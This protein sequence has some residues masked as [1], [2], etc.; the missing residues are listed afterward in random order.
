VFYR[1]LG[2]LHAGPRHTEK[3]ER[4]SAASLEVFRTSAGGLEPRKAEPV[5]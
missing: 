2:T 1:S 5:W 4:I 3:E